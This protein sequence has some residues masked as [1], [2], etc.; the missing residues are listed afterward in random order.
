MSNEKFVNPFVLP[1]EQ[2]T[3]DINILNHYAEDVSLFL[4]IQ[5]GK[6]LDQCKEYVLKNLG[7]N[8]KYPFKNENTALL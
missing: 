2:Y 4:S 1:A 8:G 6:P 5:T 7:K 3:R